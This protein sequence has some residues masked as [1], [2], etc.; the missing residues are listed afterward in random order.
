[1]RRG[2]KHKMKRRPWTKKETTAFRKAYPGTDTKILAARLKR[3]VC[4]LYGWATKCGVTK[5]AAYQ[6]RK[7]A[8]E[9]ERLRRS[10]I[11]YRYSRGHVPANA[12]LRRPGYAPGRM[13]ATQFKKGSMSGQAAKHYQPIGSYRINADGY[14]DRKL[15]D[16]GLPQRRWQCVHRLVWIAANGPIP[17]G[18]AVTFKAG[19]ATTDVEK[20]TPDAVELV[21]RA[22]L[23]LRN[24]YH[25]NYPPEIRQVIQL[26]GALQR[27]INKLV[28]RKRPSTTK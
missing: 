10:G 3:T 21:S 14:L 25:T 27:R 13:G 2:G 19:R 26:R 9:A 11:A 15:S 20:I 1:M 17:P 22:Q 4:S 24:S 6:A 12:G 7:K 23:M 5:S 18:H 28:K 16:V 8:V